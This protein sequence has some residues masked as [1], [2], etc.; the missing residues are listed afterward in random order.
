MVEEE[1]VHESRFESVEIEEE[2]EIIS[3]VVNPDN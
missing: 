3:E 2:S 1:K